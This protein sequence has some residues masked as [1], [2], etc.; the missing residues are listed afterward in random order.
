M[1][2]SSQHYTAEL[3]KDARYAKQTAALTKNLLKVAAR[4]CQLLAGPDYRPSLRGELKLRAYPRGKG[5]VR[6][7]AHVDGKR[8][9]C[10]NRKLPPSYIHAPA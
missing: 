9:H 3:Y 10:I 1:R 2:S 4:M 5:A 8:L 6:L 7:G